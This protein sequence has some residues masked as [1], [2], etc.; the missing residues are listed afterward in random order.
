[1]RPRP[2]YEEDTLFLSRRVE[3]RENRL[4]A[5]AE[6][7]NGIGYLLAVY[8]EEHNVKLSAVTVLGDHYHAVGFDE[9]AVT[10]AF[11]RDLHART[12]Y[13]VNSINGESGR[14][15]DGRQTSHVRLEEPSDIL[16]EIAYTVANLIAAGMVEDNDDYP[17]I[18]MHWGQEPQTYKRP[19][20]LN[21]NRKRANGTYWAA[22]AT[23]TMY[24]PA[25]FEE[26]SDQQLAAELDRRIAGKVDE[27]K[28]ATKER[29]GGYL[30][31]DK[32]LATP[33]SHRF[34]SFE[35]EG[36]SPTVA[37]KN[38]VR[39]IARLAFNAD[40]RAQHE[41]SRLEFKAGN[42]DVDF[43]YGTYQ[44]RVLYNVNVAPRPEPEPDPEP[45][46]SAPDVAPEPAPT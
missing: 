11:T 17:G 16:D 40:W 42:R 18:V 6:V 9:G 25:G 12:T 7:V 34:T 41:D 20:C 30:G 2:I 35:A 22:E 14:M 26:M 28:L 37:A 38:A 3:H 31:P 33:R 27:A 23:L 10:P 4:R 21:P 39:R 19:A 44:M 43:P 24:R 15:W 13:V 1:M 36:I 5:D 45:A 29:G 32:I 8:T 46:E